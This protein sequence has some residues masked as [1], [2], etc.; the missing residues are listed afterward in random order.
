MKKTAKKLVVAFDVT[1]LSKDEIE[2][3]E[4]EAVASK[5]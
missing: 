4:L 5:Q 1:D 3:L 2:E